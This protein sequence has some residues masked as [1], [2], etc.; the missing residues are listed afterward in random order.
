MFAAARTPEYM[1]MLPNNAVF[2][3]AITHPSDHVVLFPQLLMADRT[4][5]DRPHRAA[6]RSAVGTAV[7][8]YES[9]SFTWIDDRMNSL[10]RL[11]STATEGTGAAG[12]R[13]RKIA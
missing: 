4:S 5:P 7:D 9:D 3:A 11:E 1:E 10:P 2:R 12:R 6:L 8:L 13:F